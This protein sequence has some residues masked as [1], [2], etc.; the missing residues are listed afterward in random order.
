MIPRLCGVALRSRCSVGCSSTVSLICVLQEFLLYGLSGASCYNWFLIAIDY[1]AQ[2]WPLRASC[3]AGAE[4]HQAEIASAGFGTCRISLWICCLWSLLD[5]ALMWFEDCQGCAVLGLLGWT[6]VQA[7]VRSCV[8]LALSNLFVT[9]SDPHFVATS[10]RPRGAWGG[11]CCIPW[12]VSASTEPGGRSANIPRYPDKINLHL[13][14]LACC[15]LGLV[16][17][18]ASSCTTQQGINS[19]GWSGR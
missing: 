2:F 9:T 6:V 13:S 17:G 3:Y 12:L 4:F 15:L 1:E 19:I 8:W 11:L 16:T 7:S 18:K 14:L 5:S 10:A